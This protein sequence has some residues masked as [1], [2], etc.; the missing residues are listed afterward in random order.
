MIHVLYSDRVTGYT[1]YNHHAPT[2]DNKTSACSS[3]LVIRSAE[4][5]LIARLPRA[6]GWEI[7]RFEF[8]RC[9]GRTEGRW[10]G[11]LLSLTDSEHQLI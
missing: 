6:Q 4:I 10:R 7:E 2:T 11:E 8:A 9:D 1:S 5:G 3:S